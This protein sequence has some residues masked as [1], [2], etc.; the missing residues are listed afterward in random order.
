M[1]TRYNTCNF[2]V[3]A[4][5]YTES[6]LLRERE[7]T[8]PMKAAINVQFRWVQHDTLASPSWAVDDI[9][10]DCPQRFLKI[11]FEEVSR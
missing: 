3:L 6:E 2:S 9:I 10:I 7:F 1:V 5:V 11:S 8:V 4:F